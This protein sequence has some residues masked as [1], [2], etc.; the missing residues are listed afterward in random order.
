VAGLRR[1]WRLVIKLRRDEGRDIGPSITAQLNVG[2]G[3]GLNVGPSARVNIGLGAGLNV[4]LGAG[5]N[6]RFIGNRHLLA[7]PNAAS[8]AR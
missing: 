7:I 3:A 4:G 5:L 6:A 2:L 8:A 1:R